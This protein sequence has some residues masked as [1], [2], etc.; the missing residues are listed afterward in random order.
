LFTSF[1][2]NLRGLN[3]GQEE[4]GLSLHNVSNFKKSAFFLNYF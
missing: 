4:N 2:T 1:F 3:P